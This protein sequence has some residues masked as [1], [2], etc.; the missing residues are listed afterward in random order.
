MPEE[1]KKPDPTPPADDESLLARVTRLLIA[2]RPYLFILLAI[3]GAGSGGW[4]ILGQGETDRQ[5]GV[6]YAALAD[7]VNDLSEK[8]AFLSGQ[9]SAHMAAH[10]GASAEEPT[11]AMERQARLD[12][13]A[14]AQQGAFKHAALVV[15]D[16]STDL[17]EPSHLL[18]ASMPLPTRLDQLLMRVA[19]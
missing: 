12:A 13:T 3:G 15:I 1:A 10:G 18:P 7:R 5:A 2:A 19:K 4:A 6:A 11:H 17:P 16:G 14:R 8:V 9:L